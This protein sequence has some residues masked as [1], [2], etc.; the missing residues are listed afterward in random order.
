MQIR[1]RVLLVGKPNNGKGLTKILVIEKERWHKSR[2][3]GKEKK[4]MKRTGYEIWENR[5]I[6][7][8]GESLEEKGKKE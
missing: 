5:K 8:Q 4:S 7:W 3:W 1:G 6:E 2:Q